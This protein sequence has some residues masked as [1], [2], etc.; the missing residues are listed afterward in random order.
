MRK[1]SNFFMIAIF[2]CSCA[3]SRANPQETQSP[4]ATVAQPTLTA[5]TP[6]TGTPIPPTSTPD[7]INNICS[8]LEGITLAELAGIVTQPYKTP[9]PKN[10]DGHHGVDF[11][12]YRFND[13]VGIEGM[14]INAALEGEVVTVINDKNPYGYAMIVETPLDKLEPALIEALE[15]PE[16]QPTVIPDP[17][18]NCP[19]SGEM[20]FMLSSAER[21]VYVLYGH[22]K[23]MPLV[24][25]GGKVSC[26]QQL[27]LVGNS[28]QSSNAHL[29]LE[30]RVGPSGARF[31]SMA[32]YTVQ[33]T[34][35]ERY[36]YCIWRVSNLFELFDPMILL[37]VQN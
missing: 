6:P 26:G 10:D 32:Y 24:Q 19:T 37:S 34:E 25:V 16:V 1:I 4:S 17:R 28:G 5:T 8:P 3:G 29:H 30:T 31:E 14:P 33:S 9:H 18:V 20:T 21:S 15:L 2:L 22:M 23:E 35:A 11:A 13:I 7:Y 12:F 36:N 27:G